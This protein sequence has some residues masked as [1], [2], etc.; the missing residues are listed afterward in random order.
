MSKGFPRIMLGICVFF[1]FMNSWIYTL[2]DDNTRA[3]QNAF[4]KEQLFPHTQL[5]GGIPEG[6]ELPQDQKFAE[7]PIPIDK[8]QFGEWPLTAPAVGKE[9]RSLKRGEHYGF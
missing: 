9:S 3:Q 5:H 6:Y 4:D 1:M 2:R 7:A 8:T